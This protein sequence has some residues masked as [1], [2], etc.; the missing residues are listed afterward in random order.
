MRTRFQKKQ[1]RKNK[2]QKTN[3][4]TEVIYLESQCKGSENKKKNTGKGRK[5]GNLIPVLYFFFPSGA[6]DLVVS[7]YFC[8]CYL[9]GSAF[10]IYN[11][12]AS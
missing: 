9:A 6:V 2:K 5:L 8:C 7:N 3:K 1:Q 11:E 4:T 12:I 10:M